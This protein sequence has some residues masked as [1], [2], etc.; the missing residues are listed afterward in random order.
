MTS[1]QRSC[2]RPVSV[3][4]QLRGSR[5]GLRAVAL[6]L[7]KRPAWSA[8]AFRQPVDVQS[9]KDTA[10]AAGK[11]TGAIARGAST[12]FSPKEFARLVSLRQ[13]CPEYR[14]E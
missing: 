12:R 3:G 14:L 1:M 8:A 11:S 7:P 2:A 5:C 13:S 4:A 6:A 9:K 10:V